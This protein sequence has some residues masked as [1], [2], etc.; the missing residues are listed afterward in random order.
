[1]RV[2]KASNHQRD[3]VTISSDTPP[4]DG[5]GRPLR[6]V[7][8]DDHRFVRNGLRA[9][10]ET[11]GL[12]VAGEAG[13]G[14]EGVRVAMEAE[15]DVVLLDVGLPDMSGVEVVPLLREAVPGTAVVMMSASGRVGDVVTALSAGAAAYLLKE[16]PL[17][18]V[19]ATVRSAA[20]GAS[21]LS[22][23]I[24][25][26]VVRHLQEQSV[27]EPA[28]P[29]APR[30]ELT[31]RELDVLRLVAAGKANPEI[32]QELCVSVGSVKADL[33]DVLIKLGVEN[34]VQAAVT[35][36]RIGLLD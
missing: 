13:T 27:T 28:V 11:A 14:R 31:E 35:A 26:R 19:V 22:P 1:M 5:A 7:L 24:S 30:P 3:H 33:A 21:R 4:I 12:V 32:A 25:G 34:R 6:L 23:E 15:P 20:E 2:K 16:A 9:M 17:E 8:I 10:L 18:E 36:V 29:D